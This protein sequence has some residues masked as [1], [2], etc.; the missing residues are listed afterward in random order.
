MDPD[1]RDPVRTEKESA[2]PS[3]RSTERPDAPDDP[4]GDFETAND[5]TD[6]HSW[7]RRRLRLTSLDGAEDATNV[8]LE[9]PGVARAALEQDPPELVVDL[10]PHVLSDDE[11]VAAVGRGGVEVAGWADEPVP[12]SGQHR[13]RETPKRAAAS[14]AAE[15]NLVDEASRESFPASDPPSFWGRSGSDRAP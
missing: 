8:V 13:E 2:A 15:S 11:L 1:R 14:R 4:I 7:V 9:L 6:G 12:A 10:E 3:R 5:P